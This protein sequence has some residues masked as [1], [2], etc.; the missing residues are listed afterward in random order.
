MSIPAIS[1]V[2]EQAAGPAPTGGSSSPVAAPKAAHPAP[3]HISTESTL[4]PTSEFMR[5]VLAAWSSRYFFRGIYGTLFDTIEHEKGG[6]LGEFRNRMQGVLAKPGDWLQ[7]RYP[8]SS[9][10]S[11]EAIAY[12]TTL[13]LG[14]LALTLSYSGMVYKDIKSLFS[15]AV[16]AEFDKPVED[17]TFRDISRSE[18]KIVKQTINNFWGKLAQ[19]AG[20]NMLFFPAAWMRSSGLGDWVLG[21]IGLQLFT[22]TWKRKTTMFE[23]LVTFVNNKINPRNGL[24]QP[25]SQGEVFDLYQHFNDTFHPERMFTNVMENGTGEGVRWAKSQPI[26]QRLTELLNY[27]YAYKHASVID[28]DTGLAIKQADFALP[29]FI[30]LLGHDLI[31]SDQPERTLTLIEIANKHGIPAVKQSQA[32]L[33]NGASLAQLREQ[34]AVTLPDFTPKAPEVADKNATIA[35][36]SSMQVDAAPA[37][38]IDAATIA[39]HEAPARTHAHHVPA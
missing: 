12:N 30:Y 35:K 39:G 25:I 31:D 13:G 14:S 7:H 23:D 1:A 2:D 9:R 20:V 11:K 33:A 22:D 26:F 17:V 21:L 16:A 38:T 10:K 37:A 28:P 24:G 36:G 27:T 5:Y 4:A 19:R 3:P 18:N 29:K 15:E 6:F 32:L 34:F 8:T